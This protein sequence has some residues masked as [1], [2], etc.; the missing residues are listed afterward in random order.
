MQ[1][2]SDLMTHKPKPTNT[3]PGVAYMLAGGSDWSATDPFA[4]SGTLIEEPPHWMLMWP[5]DPKT[6]GFPTTLGAPDDQ[7]AA[8]TVE[9]PAWLPRSIS[10]AT[11]CHTDRSDVTQLP[12]PRSRKLLIHNDSKGQF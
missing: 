7:P 9:S 5:L 8:V 2:I 11:D 4:T 1:W 6:S 12:C 10:E 3:E